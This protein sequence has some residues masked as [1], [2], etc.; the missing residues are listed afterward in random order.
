MNSNLRAEVDGFFGFKTVGDLI[1][2]LVTAVIV[3]GALAMLIYFVYGGLTWL[4]AGGD[5]AKVDSAQKTITNAVIG[6]IIVI[7]AYA[8]FKLVIGFLGLNQLAP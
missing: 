2:T 1:S 5:K 8:L 3:A 7:T 6:L 4:T